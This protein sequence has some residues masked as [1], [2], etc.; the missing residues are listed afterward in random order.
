MFVFTVLLVF[1]ITLGNVLPTEYQLLLA[2]T[3]V[4]QDEFAY[5]FDFTVLVEDAKRKAFETRGFR[6]GGVS[7]QLKLVA[8]TVVRVNPV[9]QVHGAVVIG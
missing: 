7:F 8:L 9:E 5:P 4:D 6:L 3:V 2:V 1:Q